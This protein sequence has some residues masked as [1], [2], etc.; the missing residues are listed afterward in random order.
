M[1]KADFIARVAEKTGCT[2]KLTEEMLDTVLTEIGNV[3][4]AQDKVNFVG[5]GTFEVKQR[6]E[7][8]V[9][10]LQN[11][12]TMIVPAAAVP[13]FRPGKQLKEKVNEK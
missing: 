3:L 11:D 6:G 7:R 13:V 9:H 2:K 8:R 10:S 12:S 4:A 5:F 1:K